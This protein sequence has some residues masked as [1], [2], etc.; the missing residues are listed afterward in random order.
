MIHAWPGVTGESC[1]PVSMLKARVTELAFARQTRSRVVRESTS[2]P[3]DRRHALSELTSCSHP[4]A[5]P[6]TYE[7]SQA[8]SSFGGANERIAG[9][10]SMHSLGRPNKIASSQPARTLMMER[11]RCALRAM[12]VSGCGS[13]NG[14][15]TVDRASKCLFIRDDLA[16]S[17]HLPGR[18]YPARFG[19]HVISRTTGK[20]GEIEQG[21]PQSARRRSP[22]DSS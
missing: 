9:H 4:Y 15:R 16:R 2:T 18:I 1:R 14:D 21:T 13:L 7:S 12:T 5:C 11:M 22:D 10:L 17:G 3:S 19:S 8:A 20:F 6:R